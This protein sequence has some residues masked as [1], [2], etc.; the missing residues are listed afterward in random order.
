MSYIIRRA[1]FYLIAAWASIT[2]NF[3]LPRMMPGDP[4]SVL[5]AKLRGQGDIRPDDD[6][7][8]HSCGIEYLYDLVP[9]EVVQHRRPGKG[10]DHQRHYRRHH[11]ERWVADPECRSSENQVAD[12]ATADRNHTGQC[13][14]TGDPGGAELSMIS[15]PG[16]CPHHGL[17]ICGDR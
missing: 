9:V 4:G 10:D 16:E 13:D 6:E 5:M 11:D 12:G 17:G 2:L 15:R 1:I 8:G 3:F 7:Q 14:D